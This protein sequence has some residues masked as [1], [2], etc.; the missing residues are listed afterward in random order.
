MSHCTKFDF[1][2]T[3][4]G[5]IVKAFRKLDIKCSTELVSEFKSEFSKQVLGRLGYL[6]N[7]Q[8]RAICGINGKYNIF[9][10]KIGENDYELF[11]ERSIIGNNDNE[12]MKTL[13]DDFQR[14]YIEVAIDEIVKKLDKGN[15][16]SK[17]ESSKNKY[18]VSFGS[19][20]E[21]SLVVSFEEGKITEEV[22]GVKGD[23]CTKLTED[24]EN[25]L[26]HPSTELVTEWKQE[27]NMQI[28]DQNIQVLSLSF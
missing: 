12:E 24:I 2:Y 16:P 1:K 27:Y 22:I 7:K 3:N 19:S 8:Y 25:I 11:V 20:Y 15:M 21:Y 5:A 6:G 9:L 17:V 10:C 4:E 26:S 23:F 13:S 14:A 28:E 18:I